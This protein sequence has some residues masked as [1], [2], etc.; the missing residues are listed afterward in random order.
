MRLGSE[1]PTRCPQN[2][3]RNAQTRS[4]RG[5]DR[6]PAL[7]QSL[8]VFG[9]EPGLYPVLRIA[10]MRLRAGHHLA[11]STN[12]HP[13]ET[14]AETLRALEQVTVL[15]RASV[16]PNDVFGIGLRLSDGAAREPVEPRVIN[17]LRHWL[18]T[19]TCYVFTI[20]GFPFGKF[21]GRPVKERVFQPDWASEERLEYPNRLFEILVRILPNDI[22]GSLSTLPGSFK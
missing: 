18:D 15:V 8:P 4:H 10:G 11:Y 17:T 16:A 20:N 7:S 13:G 12:V 22:D 2:G 19:N 14:W 6:F 3:S 9:P 5:R 1:R 21:H